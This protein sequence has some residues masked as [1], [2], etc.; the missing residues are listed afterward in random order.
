MKEVA[1]IMSVYQ[2]DKLQYVKDALKSLYSQTMSA[3]I[4]IYQD[5]NIPYELEEYL[6][7]ELSNERIVHLEKNTINRGLAYSMNALLN[8][9]LD[10]YEYIMRMD[11]DD[12]SVKNRISLQYN[13]LEKH[14]DIDVVGGYIEEFS[15]DMVYK[16]I[17]QYPLSQKEMFD[18]FSKRVPLAHV[19]AFFR[20]SFFHNSGYYATTTLSNED[21]LLW[22]QGFKYKAVF[23]NIP[24]VLVNVRVSQ[25][26]F[27]RRGGIAKAWSDF[28]DR[29]LV[30]KTLGYN[31]SSYFYAIALFFVNIAPS[32]IKQFLYKR[33]R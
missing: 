8:I 25:S 10:K 1:V 21:T 17:V 28:K 30:I 7:K 19:T 3:D 33:L 27:A 31:T 4:Y 24:E 13:F 22:M 29:V 32:K 5:G 23:A 18:F 6:N 16:K 26:F 9:T 14:K 12:I 20:K 15:I 2:G 11:A